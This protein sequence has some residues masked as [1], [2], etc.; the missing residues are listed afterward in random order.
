MDE[1]LN[2]LLE[3]DITEALWGSMGSPEA[4]NKLNKKAY[5]QIEDVHK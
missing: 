5:V 3:A 4:I 2:E 1:A